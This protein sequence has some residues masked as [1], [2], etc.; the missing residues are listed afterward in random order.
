MLQRWHFLLR[1]PLSSS[2][3]EEWKQRLFHQ[4]AG[5]H[6]HGRPIEWTMEFLWNQIIQITARSPISGCAIDTLFR[7]VRAVAGPALL[8]TEWVPIL[9][10]GKVITKKFYEIIEMYQSGAWVPTW[11]IIQMDE[12]GIQILPL[13]ESALAIHLRRCE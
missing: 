4:L 8:G 6:T 5:W 2:E 12:E 11:R 9:L 1:T 13:D 10:E 7:A 3:K